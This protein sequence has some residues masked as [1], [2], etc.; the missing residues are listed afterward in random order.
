MFL[1]ALSSVSMNFDLALFEYVYP[2]FPWKLDDFF[3]GG[4][5]FLVKLFGD[6]NLK[7]LGPVTDIK[8]AGLQNPQSVLSANL[9]PQIVVKFT[10][11][12]LLLLRSQIGFLLFLTY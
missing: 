1:K 5:Y 9:L 2:L 7:L 10:Q 11:S 8:Q 6:L 3:V 12:P 4:K